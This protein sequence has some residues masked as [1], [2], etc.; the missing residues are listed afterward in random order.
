MKI[1]EKTRQGKKE[2]K[3]K[4]KRFLDLSGGGFKS[5]SSQ[6]TDSIVTERC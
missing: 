4:S 1:K 3:K 5:G 2:K 6:T